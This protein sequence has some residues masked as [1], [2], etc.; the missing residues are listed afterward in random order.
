MKINSSSTGNS[1]CFS[2]DNLFQKIRNGQ[3]EAMEI[4][5]SRY[6]IRLCRFGLSYETNFCLVEE[7]VADVYIQLRNNR[8]LLDTIKNLKSYIYVIVKNNLKTARKS[9]QYRRQIDDTS[10]TLFL[11]SRAQEIIENE[12]NKLSIYLIIKALGFIPKKSR[13][14]FK[15]SKI[16]GLKYKEIVE[17]LNVTSKTVENHIAIARKY[18]SIALESYKRG[19]VLTSLNN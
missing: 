13:Q 6:Y 15:L 16:D 10:T 9:E 18:I 12:N 19:V 8:K 17:I 4:F 2:D 3:Y 14:A 7:T 5:F 1:N 11:S